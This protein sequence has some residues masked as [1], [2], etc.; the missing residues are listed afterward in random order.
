MK[1]RVEG[2]RG[3]A[4]TRR[5]RPKPQ[6]GAG[7]KSGATPTRASKSQVKL[8]ANSVTAPG[9]RAATVAGYLRALPPDRREIISKL[10]TLILKNLPTGYK[11]TMGWGMICYGIPLSTYPVTYNGQPLC[12]LALA[13]QK[14]HLAIYA[15]SLYPKSGK[16]R[17][18]REDF[19]NA[20]KTLDMGKSCIRFKTLADLPLGVIR[21]LVAGTSVKEFIGIYERSRR[22]RK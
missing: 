22:P 12:Y 6:T 3:V 15:M 2:K 14:H 4:P 10:R 17:R 8:N 1:K 18:F 21:K 20:G 19:S 16:E 9:V 5:Y 13:S 7:P 11:E